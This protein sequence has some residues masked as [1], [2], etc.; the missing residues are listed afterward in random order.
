MKKLYTLLNAAF[1]CFIGVFLGVSLYTCWD[2]HAHPG[3]YELQSEPWYMCI[4]I[5]AVFTVA[6]CG[7]LALGMWILR[8]KMK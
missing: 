7:I 4:Q 2:Y 6:A 3:L 5:H 8:K 1:W